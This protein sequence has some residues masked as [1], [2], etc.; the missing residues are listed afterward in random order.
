MYRFVAVSATIPNAE[1]IATWLGGGK[2]VTHKFGEE[3]RPVKLRKVG[4]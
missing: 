4:P 3:R 1:D 2:A